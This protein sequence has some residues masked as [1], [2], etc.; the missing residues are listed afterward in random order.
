MKRLIIVFVIIAAVIAFFS[1]GLNQFLTLENIKANLTEFQQWRDSAP[2]LV[3]LL[4]FSMYVLV[5][6]LSLPGAAIMTLAGGALFGLAW[7]FVIVSFASTIGATLAFLVARYLLRDS[8]QKRF[9]DR[10]KPMNKGVEREGAFYL[11]TLRLVPIFPFFLINILMGLTP[12]KTFT[13]YWVSQLGML[14]GTVV[15]VNA[16]TQLA[17]IEGL[18]G[19]LSPGLLL[20]FAL[21][22]VFPLLAKKMTE[23][24]K[25]RKVYVN[26]S[27]PAKFDRN[28][29]VI[30]AG[31]AG[32]VSS[33][34]A[35]AVK[36]KVTLVEAHKMGGDCLNY[37][38]VPSKALIKSAK[39]VHHMRN[40]AQYGLENIDPE[41]SFKKVMER[42]QRVISTVEPH[43]SIERYT[44]LGVEVLQGYAEDCRSL[45]R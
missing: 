7:G 19:I 37:G 4:F 38:C 3:S 16:G 43:D 17:K 26:W 5:T 27:K 35:A 14:A 24:L 44:G 32:L 42:V 13:Y 1:L 21:L 12:I 22:G 25:K 8:V 15:Y 9:G 33:Y 10:L 31:A 20:S 40:C 18:H 23:F 28:L 30:G 29:I 41:F 36:A 6:A 45:D 2:V 39:M 34:I 11:F